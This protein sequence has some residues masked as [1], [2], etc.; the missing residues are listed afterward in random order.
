[1]TAKS[2]RQSI[3]GRKKGTTLFFRESKPAV[4]PTRLPIPG[5]AGEISC[6]LKR[7]EHKADHEPAYNA[8]V[9][10]D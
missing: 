2:R 4:A 1:M 6:W 3:P 8:E 7:A 5:V 10:N 9:K